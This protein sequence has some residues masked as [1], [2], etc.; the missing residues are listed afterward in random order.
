[1][2]KVVYSSKFKKDYKLIKKRGDNVS[3]FEKVL[4]M[5]IHEEKLPQNYSDN[6]LT[7]N[8]IGFRECH[9]EPDWLL[10]YKI[11]KD[12]LTLTLTRT[13]THNDLFR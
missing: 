6:A 2:L 10:I 13:G 1:M 9:I 8:F 4:E 11:E 3:K 7:G 5:L 12:I